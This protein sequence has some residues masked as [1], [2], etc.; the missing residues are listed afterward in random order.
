MSREYGEKKMGSHELKILSPLCEVQF[1][2]K[3]QSL[4][5]FKDKSALV[6]F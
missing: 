3:S 6:E 1:Q 2:D 5:I 4:E